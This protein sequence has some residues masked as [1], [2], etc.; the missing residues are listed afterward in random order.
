MS[1]SYWVNKAPK[2]CLPLEQYPAA[3]L[4][5]G[6]LQEAGK[7]ISQDMLMRR[8]SRIIAKREPGTMPS[9]PTAIVGNNTSTKQLGKATDVA[10]SGLAKNLSLVRTSPQKSKKRDRELFS[11]LADST[12]F[13][14]GPSA[15]S[16]TELGGELCPERKASKRRRLLSN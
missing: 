6:S 7:K 8:L 12:S 2:E 9:S 3:V 1:G 4:N 14:A 13:V 15:S 11:D 10:H 5:V 16:Q